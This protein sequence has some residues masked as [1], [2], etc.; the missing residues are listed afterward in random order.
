MIK[1]KDNEPKYSRRPKLLILIAIAAIGP[2]AMNILIPSIPKLMDIFNSSY[3]SVQVTLTAY[4]ISMAIA[5]LFVGPLS[6]RFGRRPVVL[7]GS[8]ICFS[9]SLICVFATQIDYLVFGRVIQAIGACT[10][11]VMSRTI[12]RDIHGTERAASMIAYV[13]MA[14]VVVPMLS[15]TLGGVLDNIFGWRASFIFVAIYA[16]LLFIICARSLGE[17]HK[18]PFTSVSILKMLQDYC[19]LMRLIKFNRH[20]LQISFSSVAFFSFLGGSPYVVIELMNASEVQYGF[21]FVIA[22]G[23]YMLG[24]LF[25]GRYGA[26]LGIQFCIFYGTLIGLIGGIVLTLSFF[27][28]LL[29]PATLFISMEIIAIG[30]G[31]CLPSGSAAAISVNPRKIGTAAGLAGFLQLGF[32]SG[33]AYLTG[34]LLDDSA[35]PLVI[36][37]GVSVFIAFTI[38]FLKE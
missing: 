28:E 19:Y 15:P 9:G 17:T 7:L 23:A 11:I 35:Y 33:G 5:Q 16:I 34:I 37:M 12:I 3:G 13:T 38:N 14:M 36:I 4:L 18:G 26:S 30:N 2:M 29:T 31:I 1:K 27:M 8:G 32:G 10:G 25:A 21:Y 20:A 24:N 22:G 6:D